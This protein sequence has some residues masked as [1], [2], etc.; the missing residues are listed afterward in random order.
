[1]TV[2]GVLGSPRRAEVD[3]RGRVVLPTGVRVDWIVGADDRWHVASADVAVRQRRAGPA[4]AVETAMRIPSGDAVHRVYGVGGRG[5]LVVVEVE[6]A[7]PAPFVLGV[8][9][10]GGRDL[11]VEGGLVRIDGSPALIA[12]R[13]P[14]RWSAGAVGAAASAAMAGNAT[15]E[16]L[17]HVR[18]PEIV[19][20]WP[21]T[22][23][24]LARFALVLDPQVDGAEITTP[25]ALPSIDDVVAGWRAQLARGMR[26][27]L[28]DEALQSVVDAARADALL[29]A[30]ATTRPD[31][32]LLGALEDWGFDAEAAAAW[33]RAGWRARRQ[34]RSRARRSSPGGGDVLGEVRAALVRERGNV[35]EALPG[36]RAEW[37][38][39]SL[40]VRD[41]PTRIGRLSY[42]VRWH[43]E[44]P[45]LLWELSEPAAGVTLT[46]PA[47]DAAWSTAELA[48]ETLLRGTAGSHHA[49]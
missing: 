27:E 11:R 34:A 45:A 14:A 7:S 13:A 29:G 22:H 2:V 21:V 26:V 44:H 5:D 30:A 17:A 38:G 46:A 25:A 31:A 42:S 39:T 24:T 9:V 35:I 16:P 15:G 28:P 3:Q 20:L 23:R 12:A 19:L 36:L 37:R 8:V 47:L 32:R 40:D 48:G 43:G 33:A 6:N 49:E 1:M 18:A 10:Q 4:P 41:A